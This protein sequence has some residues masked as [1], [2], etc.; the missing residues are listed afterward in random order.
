MRDM[1]FADW[2]LPLFQVMNSGPKI[3][4][5]PSFL[6][7]TAFSDISLFFL[8]KHGK[9]AQGFYLS[10]HSYPCFLHAIRSSISWVLE[11][12]KDFAIQV[13]DRKRGRGSKVGFN[14]NH[15]RSYPEPC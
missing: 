6:F 8:L 2:H 7:F 10:L 14:F 13:G 11:E 15:A 3:F 12:T 4:Y 9:I 1:C 5:A